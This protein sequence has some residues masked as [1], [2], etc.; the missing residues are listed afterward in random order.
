[1]ERARTTTFEH[2]IS[3]LL[4]KRADLFKEESQL[5]DRLA[6]IGNDVRAIDRVL[7]S[8]GYA[9]EP[10]A[11]MPRRREVLYGM[12]QLRGILDVLR[13]APE[14]LSSRDLAKVVMIANGYDPGDSKA[15]KE[16]TRRVSKTMWWLRKRGLA[17]GAAHQSGNMA[18]WAVG[19]VSAPLP[20]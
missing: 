8:L 7:A 19:Y 9:V 12:G 17:R 18:W 13:T 5:H 2:T 1:M 15:L 6:E 14:P 10:D 16:H 20:R 11:E 3:G 4:T